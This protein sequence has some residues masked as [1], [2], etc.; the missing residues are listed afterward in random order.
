[1]VN[2]VQLLGHLGV[3]PITRPLQGGD[4]VASFRMAT[5]DRWKDK[6]TGEWREKSE[7][8]NIVIFGTLAEIAERYLKKGSKVF[9]QGKLT[10]RK[11]QDQQGNDKY[12]TEVVLQGFGTILQMLDPKPEGGRQ[13]AGS[14]DGDGGGYG[15]GDARGGGN[16]SRPAQQ[17]QQQKAFDDEI[18]FAWLITVGIGASM[19]L[20]Q[21]GVLA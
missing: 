15:G 2:Q 17:K 11:W 20:L 16:G 3:D 12:T 10:T 18:P 6:Q 13:G 7:W 5:A 4:K 19:M 9:V 21:S 14:S 1:M 8:H